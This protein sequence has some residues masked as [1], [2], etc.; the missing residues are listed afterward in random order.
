[1]D[2]QDGEAAPDTLPDT[3]ASSRKTTL[4]AAGLHRLSAP[5][6]ALRPDEARSDARQ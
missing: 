6:E 5:I 1:M 3:L 4:I 2:G